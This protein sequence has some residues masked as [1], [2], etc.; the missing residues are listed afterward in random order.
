VSLLATDCGSKWQLY[1][2]KDAT[3]IYR[4]TYQHGRKCWEDFKE[5]LDTAETRNVRL[6][7]RKHTHTLTLEN[8]DDQQDLGGFE[9]E[10][11][12]DGKT[13]ALERQAMLESLASQLEKIYGEHTS[14]PYWAR[15]EATCPNYYA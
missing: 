11:E 12:D 5:L 13:K 1:H 2:F 14:V 9:G 6:A 8:D 4:R 7:K 10:Y 3:T 15:A